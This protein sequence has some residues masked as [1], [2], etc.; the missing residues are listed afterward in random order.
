M[1]FKEKYSEIKTSNKQT[2]YSFVHI[3]CRTSLSHTN[4]FSLPVIFSAWMWIVSWIVPKHNRETEEQFN[5]MSK[6]AIFYV[7]CVVSV[8][9]NGNPMN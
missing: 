4:N 7:C 3:G 9:T 8:P 2:K 6:M 1:K 5:I